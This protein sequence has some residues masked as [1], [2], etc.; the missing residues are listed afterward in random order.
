MLHTHAHT[1]TDKLNNGTLYAHRYEE[2]F[3]LEAKND[4]GRCAPSALPHY[5]EDFLPKG[6]KRPRLLRSLGLASLLVER[7]MRQGGLILAT[8]RVR[9]K[10]KKNR[11]TKNRQNTP[12]P[13][14]TT[15]STAT[16]RPRP[17]QDIARRNTSHTLA[18]TC[19]LP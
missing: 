7:Y 9:S 13:K 4:L 11:K 16:R 10:E 8:S 15:K 2:F 5:E 1:P 17:P 3:R 6:K 12:H 14:H 18:H 19:P